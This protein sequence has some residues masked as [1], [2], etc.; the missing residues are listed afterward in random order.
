MKGVSKL[1]AFQVLNSNGTWALLFGKP[2]LKTFR[3]VHDYAEDIINIPKGKEWITLENQFANRQGVTGDLL[4]NLTINIKQLVNLS[5]DG[6]PSPLREVSQSNVH[7]NLFAN[8]SIDMTVTT[9]KK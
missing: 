1:G 9:E 3:A 7:N 5:G 4:A 2:L 8:K 6:I